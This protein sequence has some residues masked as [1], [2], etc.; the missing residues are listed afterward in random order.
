MARDFSHLH[1]HSQY[2][3]LDGAIRIDELCNLVKEFGQSSVAL[4]DHGVM[5]GAIELQKNAKKAGLK[6][7]FGCEIYV[8]E[9]ADYLPKDQMTR[10]NYHLCV[11]ATSQVG[12]ENLIWLVSQANLHNF[13]YKPRVNQQN[14]AEHSEGLIILSGCINSQCFRYGHYDPEHDVFS[15]PSGRG[16][17]IIN[18]YRDIFGDRFYFEIQDADTKELPQQ[19][20]YNIYLNNLAAKRGISTVITADAHYLTQGHKPA[21]DVVMAMQTNKTLDQYLSPEN[22]F[23]FGDWNYV[24]SSEQMLEA[25]VKSGNSKA[26]ETT[27]EVAEKCQFEIEL[28]KYKPPVYDISN[29]ADKEEFEQWLTQQR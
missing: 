27:L 1:I 21:H 11:L 26:F 5:S 15:D 24:R 28:G 19:R 23:K 7:I 20:A 12:Y 3:I 8:T 4:T 6:P 29:V 22:E 13:Y 18:W 16:S 9:D 25:A 14:L 10:D 17:K 2:S